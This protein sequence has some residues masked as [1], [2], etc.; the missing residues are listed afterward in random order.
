MI[1]TVAVLGLALLVMPATAAGPLSQPQQAAALL[2]D[3]SGVWKGTL[4]Y[5]DYESGE[6]TALPV[7]ETVTRLPD[8]ATLQTVAAY[9]DGG[10]GTV[11]ISSLG[12]LDADTGTWQSASF[13]KGDAM[14]TGAVTLAFPSAPADATHWTIVTTE[15][16]TDGDS[17]ATIRHTI[18]R[19]GPILTTTAEYD[20]KNDDKD[21]YAFRNEVVLTLTP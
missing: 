6:R 17:P 18:T 21:E 9:D 8:N 14:E 20:R 4:T 7:I 12:A 19:N 1:R 2:L 10:A 13:R 15:D 5:L 16:G 3:T 11:Y